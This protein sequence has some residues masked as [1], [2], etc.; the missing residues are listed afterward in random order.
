MAGLTHDEI[1][2]RK[3]GT[4]IPLERGRILVF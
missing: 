1:E 4:M 2:R 3:L